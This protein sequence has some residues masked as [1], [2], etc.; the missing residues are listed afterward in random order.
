MVAIY[1][2][3]AKVGYESRGEQTLKV[4]RGQVA[5]RLVNAATVVE[6]YVRRDRVTGLLKGFES[7]AVDAL[8]LERLEERLG[9]GVVVRRPWAAHAL[10]AS[11]CGDFS[12]EIP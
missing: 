11:D 12:P 7:Y 1:R 5:K 9:A 6:Q 2:T 10:D 8:S 4:R 3:G